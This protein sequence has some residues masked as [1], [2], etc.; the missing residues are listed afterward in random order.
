M[1]KTRIIFV[2]VV[3]A[4]LI[5][6]GAVYQFYLKER[7]AELKKQDTY[8]KDLYGKLMSLDTTFEG[9]KPELLISTWRQQVQPWMDKRQ[10]LAQYFN[11]G[12]WFTLEEDVPTSGTILIYWYGEQ[13]TKML[14]KLYEE[15]ANALGPYYQ[16]LIPNIR[17]T[18]GVATVEQW[19]GQEITVTMVSRELRKLAFAINLVKLFVIEG[20]VK[21]LNEIIEWPIE[22]PAVNYEKLVI[23]RRYGVHFTSTMKDL[24]KFFGE[25]LLAPDKPKHYTIEAFR[26]KY[27]NIL[28]QQ[29]PV[30]DVQIILAMAFAK[31]DMPEPAI[32]PVANPNTPTRPGVGGGGKPPEPTG[33][34]AA[35]KW[36]KRTVLFSN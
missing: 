18:F 5:G 16:Q 12:D 27:P 4:V 10:Q 3:L 22:D 15:C 6:F 7:L 21:S 33:F 32:V 1:T 31:N 23:I 30:L 35:W 20:K 13:S 19:Q 34:A 8:K 17:E 14:Q 26:I 9:V 28:N 25:T 29:E 36:F 2:S 11:T 24:C